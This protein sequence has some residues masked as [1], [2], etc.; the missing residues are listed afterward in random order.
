MKTLKQFKKIHHTNDELIM[1][2]HFRMGDEARKHLYHSLKERQSFELSHERWMNKNDNSH[3]GKT[4]SEV[5]E[6]LVQH[7]KPRS[8]AART[9]ISNYTDESDVL[10]RKLLR[11]SKLT[12]KQQNDVN[13]LDSVTNEPAARH[14]FLYSGLGHRRGRAVR[15]AMA[16]G[17]ELTLPAYTSMTA[18]KK[19]ARNFAGVHSRYDENMS[20]LPNGQRE[21]HYISLH[22]R[23]GQRVGHVSQ[24]SEHPYEM[25]SI[26]P[27]NTRIRIKRHS[28]HVDAHG[29][30]HNVYH[31]E[32][33]HQD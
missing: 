32:I 18:S 22:V 8:E 31:A 5:A 29:N 20:E 13:N 1:H 30:Q 12:K 19:I 27:R 25:E 9:S 24:H 23:R 14:H 17:R 7:S 33:S 21:F 11:K 15:A 28:F 6:H 16:N 4:D 26:L 10:N 3:I 2:I